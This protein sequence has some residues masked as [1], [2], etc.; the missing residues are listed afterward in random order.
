MVRKRKKPRRKPTRKKKAARKRTGADVVDIEVKRAEK[1]GDE[2]LTLQHAITQGIDESVALIVG[3]YRAWERANP[4]VAL[5]P[6]HKLEMVRYGFV[7]P[8]GFERCHD[9]DRRPEEAF[10]LDDGDVH[11]CIRRDHRASEVLMCPA[12]QDGLCQGVWSGMQ[13]PPCYL[14]LL[15]VHHGLGGGARDD[16][17]EEVVDDFGKWGGP[18]EF[19]ES[20]A[21]GEEAVA[22]YRRLDAARVAA[23]ESKNSTT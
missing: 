10:Y 19:A 9:P 13:M 6:R 4:T 15:E 14:L 3:K 20:F 11:E 16:S 18:E 12:M 2:L 7:G 5:Q 8:G 21:R 22:H 17:V 1:L 23:R